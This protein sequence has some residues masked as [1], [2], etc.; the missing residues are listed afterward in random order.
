MKKILL[1]ALLIISTSVFSQELDEA[2]LE[3]LPEEVRMDVLQS[4]SDQ[5]DFVKPMY[6]RPS[7][8][9]TK[10]YCYGDTDTDNCIKKSD[11]FGENFFDMMQSSF[12]PINEPNLDSSY[13]LDFGDVLEMQLVGQ[14]DIISELAIKRDGSVNILGIG[15]VSLSGLTLQDAG[16]LIKNKI[17]NAYVGTEAFITLI[18]IRDIQVLVTGNAFNPGIYTLNG[19]S[20]L[21]H[22]LAMAGGIDNGG[23]YRHIEHIRN[24]KV[25][26]TVD[27]YDIFIFGKNMFADRLRSGD[28]ILIKPAGNLISVSGAIKRP[29]TYEIIESETFL[30]V[31]NYGNG[32]SDS[33]NESTLRI[34]RLNKEEV[35]F[36][37]LSTFNELSSIKPI[38]GDR[39]NVRSYERKRVTVS[40]AIKTP[41]TYTISQGETL[42]SL[43]R[44]AEGYKYDAYQF[45]G[46]LI[47]EQATLINEAAVSKLYRAFV[48][49]LITKGDALFASEGLPY[50]LE[51]LKQVESSGRVQAEFDLNVLK[52]YPDLDTTLNDG[53]QIIIPSVTQQ[54]YIYGEVNQPGT[55]RYKPNSSL[56]NYL[57]L[58]GGALESADL[59]NIYAIHPNGEI[60]RYDSSRISFIKN[61]NNDLVYPGSVI[62]V[63]RDI[64]IAPTAIAS[65]W[66]PILSSLA[67]TLTSLSVLDSNN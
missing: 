45:G 61:S 6:R 51:E 16:A 13:L 65:I 60:S 48:T 28:S 29:G 10:V 46:I 1:S 32:F 50:I 43:I 18:N 67:V 58:A 22:A 14:K 33:A 17:K 57:T 52:A 59:K 23:S 5:E 37:K 53:D 21:I 64:K 30:D 3:S 49:R 12:M 39:L 34:E 25:I 41:G 31:F 56:E 42:S 38:P 2:Y 15:K 7:T 9:V 55:I 4:M 11:R 47:N 19:N 63:P 54:V 26:N 24:N 35:E 62:Y 66:A 36:I 27:L 44:R 8:M 20:N 40:G